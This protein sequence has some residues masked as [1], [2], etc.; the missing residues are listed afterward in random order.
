MKF[1]LEPNTKTGV[2]SI[3]FMIIAVIMMVV[4][5]F[6]AED[7]EILYEGGFLEQLNLT[8]MTIV[9]FACSIIS[10]VTGVLAI[11]RDKETSILCY[12]SIIL[13]AMVVFFGTSVFIGEVNALNPQTK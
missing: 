9:A 10:L 4:V 8:I 12:G 5:A 13:S 6:L 3:S 11:K 7:I 2:F 1:T